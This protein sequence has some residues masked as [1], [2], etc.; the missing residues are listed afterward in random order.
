MDNIINY[1]DFAVESSIE[2]L[3]LMNKHRLVHLSMESEFILECMDCGVLSPVLEADKGDSIFAKAKEAINKFF[4]KILGLFRDRSK[5]KAEKYVPWVKENVDSIKTRSKNMTIELT[6]YWKTEWK[7][8]VKAMTNAINK[9]FQ[10]IKD[11]KYDDYSFAN[12][13]VKIEGNVS[14]TTNLKNKLIVRFSVG[15]KDKTVMEQIK[16]E[17]FGQTDTI[18]KMLQYILAYA[19]DVPNSMDQL[20]KTI[21]RKMDEVKPKSITIKESNFFDVEGSILCET[22]LVTLI[23]YMEVITEAEKDNEPKG[24]VNSEGEQTSDTSVKVNPDNKEGEGTPEENK[25]DADKEKESNEEKDKYISQCESFMKTMVTAFLTAAEKRFVVYVNTMVAIGNTK[26]TPTTDEDGNVEDREEKP[27]DKK[28]E[29]TSNEKPK[30]KE[31][32]GGK[33]V[34]KVKN[35]AN[36]LAGKKKTE[37]KDK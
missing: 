12:D 6:P 28:T 25:E 17:K 5:E 36:N 9:I 19:S 23:N 34:N 35:V 13:F 7:D 8:D 11:G 18:D 10:N 30:N 1:T 2:S 24:T 21:E 14:D 16:V 31:T 37:T 20:Q 33:I 26:G 32:L 4:K 22:D 15:E 27:E 3:R 29:E